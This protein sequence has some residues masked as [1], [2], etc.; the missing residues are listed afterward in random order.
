[1]VAG[2]PLGDGTLTNLVL[3]GQ[4]RGEEQMWCRYQRA[5]R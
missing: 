5:I 1:L 4:H 2:C 3:A